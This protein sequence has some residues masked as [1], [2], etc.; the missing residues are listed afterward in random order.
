MTAEQFE[1]TVLHFLHQKP[2]HP[3][4]VELHDGR[5]IEINR[6]GLALGGDSASFFTT[7]FDLI[8]FACEEVR[9]IR[10]AVQGAAS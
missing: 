1:A 7:D 5:R 10:Q 2:F 6:P 8:E 9:D 4:V 3:F